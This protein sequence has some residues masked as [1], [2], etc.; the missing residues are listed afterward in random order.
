MVL[1]IT[2]K[3]GAGKSTYARR[4]E[5]EL[6]DEGIKVA[7]IDGDEWR[8]QHDNHDYSDQGRLQ[9]LVTAAQEAAALEQHGNIVLM[10]FVSPK[11]EWRYVMRKLWNQSRVVYI[12]GG[13]LWEGTTYERPDENELLGR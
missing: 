9:N 8:Q 3:A 10:A 2:G 5:K 12:P 1:L 7:V 11:R 4:L 13:N 6:I